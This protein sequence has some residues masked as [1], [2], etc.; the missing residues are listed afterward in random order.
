[1]TKNSSTL[2]K[3]VKDYFDNEIP[4]PDENDVEKLKQNLRI[5]K[6]KNKKILGFK[7]FAI[8]MIVVLILIPSIALPMILREDDRIYYRDDDLERVIME[9]N[10]AK[11]VIFDNYSIYQ[12]IFDLCNLNNAYG[13]Y[14]KDNKLISIQYYLERNEMPFTSLTLQIDLTNYYLNPNKDIYKLNSDKTEYKKYVVYEKVINEIDTT[15]VM[16]LI[17]FKSYS[18]YLNLSLEDSDIINMFIQN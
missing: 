4:E 2:D 13:Y 3:C 12:G 18:V 1:M 9:K 6:A 10:D 15:T 11:D 14:S 5:S 16:K 8:A 7:K 17:I